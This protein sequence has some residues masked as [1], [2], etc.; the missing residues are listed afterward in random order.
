[1]QKWQKGHSVTDFMMQFDMPNSS[2]E[3]VLF[4][5]EV[6]SPFVAVQPS[7]IMLIPE[8]LNMKPDNI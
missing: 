7:I 6:F 4:S 5:N 8:K 3:P 2:V 1:M